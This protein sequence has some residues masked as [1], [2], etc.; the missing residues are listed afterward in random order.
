[1]YLLIVALPLISFLI[2]ILFGNYLGRKGAAI[3]TITLLF[4]TSLLSFVVFYEVVLSHSVCTIK[5]AS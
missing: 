2:A 4:F 1:M 3:V 5:L